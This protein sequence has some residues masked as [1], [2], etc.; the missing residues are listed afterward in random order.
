[1]FSYII[2]KFKKEDGQA[3][4]EFAIILPI[5]IMILCGIIDFGWYFT[6]Q[7]I[8][9][10]CSREGAR[11]ASVTPEATEAET[12]A[13]ITTKIN[14][15]APSYLTISEIIYSYPIGDV[16]VEVFG[17]VAALTPIVGVFEETIPLYSSCTMRVE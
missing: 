5:L 2:N 4:V 16:K 17:E 8:I 14:D 13:A 15:M 6:N 9:D 12:E 1:M 7:N 10:N 11:Y 3:M